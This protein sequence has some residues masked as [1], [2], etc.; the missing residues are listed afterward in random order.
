[1]NKKGFK[2]V[3]TLCVL[4]HKNKFLL[5]KRFN[6]PNIGK[7]VP[8]GGK[9]KPYESPKNGVIRETLEETGL[10]IK[11]PIFAGILSET[12][13]TNYNWISYVFYYE[14]NFINPPLSNEGLLEWIHYKDINKL[15]TPSTDHY[16]Y[17]YILEK[18]KFIINAEYNKELKLLNMKEEINDEILK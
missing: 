6:K 13:P 15:P 8:V 4:K 12:S 9:L 3:A 17:K 14:I 7:Y 1:M 5:L 10:K 18:K 2:K 16:I 11:N